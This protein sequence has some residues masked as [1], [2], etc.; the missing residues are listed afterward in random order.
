MAQKE[1]KSLVV[2]LIL[3]GRPE[4][5]LEIL[6]KN[7]NVSVP[8]LEVGLPKGHKIRVYGCYRSKNQTISVLNSDVLS[9]PFVIIHEFYHHLRTKSVDRIHKGTERNA[10]KFAIN[11]MEAYKDQ[12]S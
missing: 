5:A 2:W 10:D 1:F 11:F 8:V 6:A 3:N 7:Y 12:Y 9:N 4:E